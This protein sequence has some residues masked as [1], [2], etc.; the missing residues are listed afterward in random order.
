VELLSQGNLF[1][2]YRSKQARE[3]ISLK[4][5]RVHESQLPIYTPTFTAEMR[6]LCPFQGFN[7]FRSAP[8]QAAGK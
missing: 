7:E 6:L 8:S 3:G 4:C 5:V 1:H 2:C